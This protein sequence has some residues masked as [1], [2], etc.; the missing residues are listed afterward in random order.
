MEVMG[1]VP[2]EDL[3]LYLKDVD[4]GVIGNRGYTEVR[5]NYML[6]VKM[7]EYAAMEIPTVAPRLRVI[8][9]YFDET[10]AIFYAPDDVEDMARRIV[11]VYR[12][13][14]ILETIRQGLRAFNRRYNWAS[15]EGRYREILDGLLDHLSPEKV[16]L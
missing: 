1:F 10:N 4:L 7:L 15:M 2:V 5:R 11:E 6:P 8:Q 12:H 3:P 13:S 16:E 14:E 9:E